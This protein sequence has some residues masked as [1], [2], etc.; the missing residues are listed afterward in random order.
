M[1]YARSKLDKT[2]VFSLRLLEAICEFR[3]KGATKIEHVKNKKNK[4]INIKVN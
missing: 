4:N 2:K 3:K 1:T